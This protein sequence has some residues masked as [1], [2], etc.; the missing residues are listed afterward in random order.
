MIW[1]IIIIKFAHDMSFVFQIQ[2]IAWITAAI[3]V[4]SFSI[5]VLSLIK[6]I[7]PCIKKTILM[8]WIM[9][10]V[11]IVVTI[12]IS[13]VVFLNNYFLQHYAK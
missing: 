8:E 5:N 4:A 7:T 6:G 2:I 10:L 1:T 12:L 9:G 13:L 3:S 11:L